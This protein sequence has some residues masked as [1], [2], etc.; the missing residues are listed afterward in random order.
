M[1]HT[2][3]RYILNALCALNAIALLVLWRH[4]LVLALLLLAIGIGILYI[5]PRVVLYGGAVLAAI[6]LEVLAV[7]VG[8]WQYTAQTFWGIPAWLPLSWANL[9]VVLS[10]TDD[11]R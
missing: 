6:V 4:P 8:I 3:R 7:H 11:R 9:I 2:P 5:R 10:A 1:K